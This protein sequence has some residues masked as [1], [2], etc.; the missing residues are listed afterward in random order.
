MPIRV[1]VTGSVAPP[2]AG[3]AEAD[4]TL[5]LASPQRNLTLSL[6]PLAGCLSTRCRDLVELAAA[7]YAADIAVPRGTNEAWVRDLELFIP[8]RDPDFWRAQQPATE[9]LL[10]ELTAD[11]IAL[12]FGL[13]RERAAQR[14]QA[15]EQDA[16][17]RQPVGRADCV[18]LLSGG[19]DS[20]AGAVV[21]LR[22]GRQPLFVSH[23]PGSPTIEGAQRQV[24]AA[25][26]QRF[27]GPWQHL[28]LRCAPA[29][30]KAP[31]PAGGSSAPAQSGAGFPELPDREPSQRS[32]S[33]L[34]M[35]LATAAAEVSGAGELYVF[36]NGILTVNIPMSP[37][38]VG[39]LSTRTTHP[40]V[41]H[42]FS[43]LAGAVLGR[44]VPIVN[45]FAL[46]TKAEVIRDALKSVMA[47]DEIQAAVSCWQAS[48]SSRACGACVPCLLRRISMLAAGLPDEAYQLDLLADPLKHPHTDALA[49]L[50][51]L[52]ALAADFTNLHDQ[53]LLGNYPDLLDGEDYGL[54]AG[55]VIDLYRRF[56]REVFQVLDEHFGATARL[57]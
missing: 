24:A 51:D 53:V 36:E 56:A 14:V 35:A 10:Y 22:T 16:A 37:A 45:P 11:N 43:A 27:P 25:L 48:R 17:G 39:S 9:A 3:F 18:S 44:P 34:F 28:S 26:R 49:N 46:R 55:L 33:F 20:F 52:V 12:R 40:R 31:P 54:S 8:V 32:R 50:T 23:A 29:R 57:R 19:L 30:R 38:R 21:L 47:I 6:G 42:L 5:D 1:A 15:G 41:L 2:P 4:L 7:V 13:L